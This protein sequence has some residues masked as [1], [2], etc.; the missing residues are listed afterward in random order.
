VPTR[1]LHISDIH[2]GTRAE[3]G[4]EEALPPI[5]AELDPGLVLFTGDLTHC[6]RRD[7]HE[8]A[9]ALLRSFERPLVVI[10]GNHDIPGWSIGRFTHTFREFDR[11]WPERE[12]VYRAPGLVV[13]GLNSVRP[14]RH[15]SGAIGEEQIARVREAFADAPEGA[16]R[17]VAVHHHLLGA[18]WRTWKPPLSRRTRTLAAFVDGGAELVVAGHVHQS[19]VAERR[20]FEVVTGGERSAVV[21][22]APGLGQPRPKRRGEARG[23]HLYEA[24]A[25]TLQAEASTLR[26]LT[27]V[28]RD[29]DWAL[30]ADRLYPRGREPLARAPLAPSSR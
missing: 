13:A 17:V 18:P 6:G 10:P 15:Q 5:V 29:E 24:E 9:A 14:Y 11:Q 28:W 23:F 16:L 7:Q 4:L 30:T 19:A 27:F 3:S 21:V 2:L 1:I 12:P 20:E 22:T 8:R 26:V 25:S